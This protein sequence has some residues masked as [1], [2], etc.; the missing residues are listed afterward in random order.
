ML[1]NN[2][3]VVILARMSLRPIIAA[4]ICFGS[5]ALAADD[6]PQFRGPSGDGHSD[7]T[8]LPVSF[9]EGN[10]VKWKTAIHGK[11]WS[12]PVILGSQ[13]WL[14]TATEDGTEL[15]VVCVDKDSGNMLQDKVLFRVETPQ[16]CHKFNSY[17]SPTPVIEE[18]RVYIT[19]GSPGTACLD[20]KTGE[21]L[22]Q[23][24]DFVCNHYRGAGSS[25]IVMGDLLIVNFDGSDAQFVV[26]LDK[27]TGKTV[28]RT[29]RSVNYNDL[30]KSGNPSGEGDYRKAFSTC[31]IVEQDGKPVLVSS[32]AKAHYGYEPLTGKELW[33]FEDPEHHSAA[34]RPVAGF[35]LIFI[36]AGFSQ[37]QVFALKPGAGLLDES[38][39]LW[40]I[41]KAAPNKPSLLLIEDLLYMINDGGIVSCVEAKTGKPVWS[42][43]VQGNY[44]AAPIFADGRIYVSSEEGKVAV[45]APGREFK[46]LAE[47]KFGSG[48]M[49]SPA[50]SGKALILRSKTHLYRVEE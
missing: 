47:N 10:H 13:I 35:G 28:W 24:T 42:E 20:T 22:W 23:R 45:L 8:G 5:I 41:K 12:S 4:F 32:G 33:R 34:T 36:A 3:K 6:W 49:A 2:A 21:V 15:S 50:V 38:H 39:C 14:T 26:A 44:S 11:G 30:D 37:G 7:S 19:F 25:P 31:E 17:A 18:G 16:F 27:K 29:E 46:L 1:P 48:F 43:R 9:D 40:R